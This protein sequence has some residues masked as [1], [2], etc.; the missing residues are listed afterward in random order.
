MNKCIFIARTTKD[1]ELRYSQGDNSM[2]IGRFSIAVDSGYGDK[3]KTNFFNMTAFGKTAETLEKYVKKG[4]KVALEC[5]ANQSQYTDKNG[6]NVNTVDFIV[7][8]FEFCESRNTQPAPEQA[9][10]PDKWMSI[11]DG[12]GDEL[13]F[14]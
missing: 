1:V 2:A 6:N 4:A 10:A 12:I 5:E 7:K 11:P 9:P 3:K 13:P 8:N 14:Q